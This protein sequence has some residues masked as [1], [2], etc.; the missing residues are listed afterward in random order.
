MYDFLKKLFAE[1]ALTFD[2]FVEAL[3]GD[4]TIKLVNLSDGG[5]VAKDKYDNK[6]RELTTELTGVKEQLTSAN[7]TIQSYKD[8][9]IEG[10][11]K[12]ASDWEKKYKDDTD[13]LTKKLEQQAYDHKADLFMS[14]YT[15]TSAAAKSGIRALFDQQKFELGED[16]VFKGAKEWMDTQIGSDEN[17]GAFVVD[18]PAAP[19]APSGTPPMFAPTQPPKGPTKHRS[20]TQLMQ[21]RNA[22]PNAPIKF[23]T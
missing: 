12:S 8:M 13:A 23:D 18:A 21:E 1:G 9:D 4:K 17:K 5:Y 11:K 10:I 22:N 6:V 7:A 19:P 14:G 3:N 15:F 16:G 2:Q 20:L